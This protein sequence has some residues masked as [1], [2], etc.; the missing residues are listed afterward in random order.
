MAQARHATLG[1]L[2]AILEPTGLRFAGPAA[3]REAL[4]RRTV[5]HE[6]RAEVS[7]APG[8]VLLAV[9]VTPSDAASLAAEAA[10]R[11]FVALAVK[12]YGEPTGLLVEVAADHG[13]AVLVVGDEMSWSALHSHL[14]GAMATAAP[15]GE[16]PA[17]VA[18]GDLFALADAI[19]DTMGGATALE[20]TEQRILA[21]SSLSDHPIDAERRDG[22]LGRVVPRSPDNVKEYQALATGT[23]PQR[24]HASPGGLPRLAIGVHA[25]AETLGSIWVVDHDGS[26]D[27]A[28]GRHALRGAAEVAALHLLRARSSAD[29]V[30]RQQAEA[31][32]HLLDGTGDP[33]DA[34]AALG[35]GAE[36]P[37]VV[38][39]FAPER[40]SP[41][42][43]GARLLPMVTLL[44]ESRVG[45]AGT[46]E[47][48]GSVYVVA[49]TAGRPERA[50]V[51]LAE[52]VVE[53]ARTS[54]RMPLVAGVSRPVDRASRV[55]GARTEVDRIIALVR[56]RPLLGPVAAGNSISDQLTL[57]ALIEAVRSDE[58]LVAARARAVLDHDA[59]HG[60]DY[61]TLL[62]THLDHGREVSRTAQ[63]LSVHQ[64]T[65]RYRLKRA[66]ELF[67]ADLSDPDQALTLWLGLRAHD[68]TTP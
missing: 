60:T 20:D 7:E 50:V 12:A 48:G 8:G 4:V 10:A 30:R 32:R 18:V 49:A 61:A 40:L 34:A 14:A 17:A 46:G 43:S 63:A 55:A 53:S 45:R 19:A 62:R 65:V 41:D 21:Y 3:A 68:P 64:N 52:Q 15:G 35:L 1:D 25:G 56:R 24:F 36:G 13:V 31:V 58:H 66:T 26:V 54:L 39:G 6:P 59:L 47:V 23:E 44:A 33:R 2:L 22:I 28:A 5:L 67:G 27:T 51:R 37:Y 9:G 29:L 11:G 16:T 42:A 57:D 38:L